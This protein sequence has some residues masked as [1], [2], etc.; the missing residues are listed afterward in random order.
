MHF[1]Q[2][3]SKWSFWTQNQRGYPL[4]IF[5]FRAGALSAQIAGIFRTILPRRQF[6]S[7][8]PCPSF[9]PLSH[10]IFIPSQ[11]TKSSIWTCSRGP[12]TLKL[13][14]WRVSFWRTFRF[15]SPSCHIHPIA[16]HQI[17]DLDV[18][19]WSLDPETSHVESI[20]LEDFSIFFSRKGE[21]KSPTG[22]LYLGKRLRIGHGS[23]Q[24]KWQNKK[25]RLGWGSG[26]HFPRTSNV[27]L[28]RSPCYRTFDTK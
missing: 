22:P 18:F 3:F 27:N 26:V 20:V 5:G 25:V 17:V 23:I 15:F 4:P 28:K 6:P 9:R 14:L 8:I 12:W 13:R 1:R 19:P 21:K 24:E 11:N 10:A 7:R 2:Y 16:K